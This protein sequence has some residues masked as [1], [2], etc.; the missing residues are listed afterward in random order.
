MKTILLSVPSGSHA[1]VLLKPLRPLFQKAI[2]EQ[3]I[4]LVVVS[5][6]RSYPELLSE[7]K[8]SG[9]VFVSWQPK[10]FD[11]FNPDLVVTTTTGLDQFDILILRQAKKR[12]IPTLTYI[13][14]WDNIY[15]M[16]R[17]KDEMIKVDT[18]LVWNQINKK[19]AKKAF[20][21]RDDD[22]HCVGSP[23]LDYFWKKDR[24]PSREEL[25]RYL[26]VD[27]QK[28]LIH[29]ATVE[30]YDISYVVKIL[31]Q[32]R[33]KGKI[34][35]PI[36]I[37]CSV[38]P[39]GDIEKHKWYAKEYGAKLRYSFG[40]KDRS[41]HPLF[42]YN[43]SLEDMCMLTS[44]WI[45]SDLM[46]NFSSTAAIESMLGDTPTINVMFG[47]PFDFFTWRKSAV[48]K[49][50]KE[51]YKEIINEKGTTV[52]KNKKQLLSAVNQYLIRPELN[53]KARIKT[54]KKMLT[55]L[56]GKARERVFQ[57]II[58]AL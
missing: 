22:I 48:V 44:L 17:R 49:D 11:H 51:H 28:K 37:Y 24:I 46:I 9:F 53:H 27:P 33:D 13:E 43:P 29:I 30:L 8:G 12:K 23:R 25:C 1:R 50:F 5:P 54:C 39:G 32:A 31:S 36:E 40:R 55:Y 10:I 3:K 6:M 18:L 38:H 7:F 56:D 14:S 2:Q 35:K 34:T 4:K 52:V 58:K 45:H 47:K 57:Y 20:G 42:R 16:E 21:Y 15:K 19:H 41:P 26:S